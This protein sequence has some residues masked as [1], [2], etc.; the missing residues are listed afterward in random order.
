MRSLTGTPR[1][2][3]LAL[4][5]DR[6][7][8]PVWLLGI[9]GLLV[10]FLA[11]YQDT[12][13]TTD[14][15]RI[16]T[17]FFAENPIARMFGL[18]SGVNLG[19]YTLIEGYL[20]LVVLVG[21][22]SILAMVRHTRQSEETRQAEMLGATAVG[23]QALL[24]AALLVAFMANAAL[25]LLVTLV[26]VSFGLSLGS[27]LV[28]GVAFGGAGLAFASV[29]AVTVQI[30][31]SSRGASGMAAGVMGA[32][33]LLSAIGS[34]LGTV[35]ESGIVVD[36]AWPSWLSPIG[37]GQLMRPFAGDNWWLLL[38]LVGFFLVHCGIAFALL[39]R[40]DQGR[41]ILSEGRGP[42]NAARGLLS[43]IGLAWRLQRGVFF[44][45]AVGLAVSGLIVGAIA[46]DME[47]S[48]ADLDIADLLVSLGGTD[49][50][51]DAYF[52]AS[53]GFMGILVSAYAIQV[54]LRMRIEESD[55]PLESLLAM[56]LS[57]TRWMLS[58]T[59]NAIAGSLVLLALTGL[60]MG[61]TAGLTLG[62]MG[63]WL[64]D[65]TLAG[66]VLAPATFVIGA[67]S[68]LIFAVLPRRAAALSWAIFIIAMLTGPMFGE[69]LN[70]PDSVQNISPY[71]HTPGLPAADFT[72]TPLVIML[73]AA[74]ALALA[75]L[76]WFRRRDLAL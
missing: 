57:R 34:M 24:A 13:R 50:L 26:F 49:Q 73:A 43:P 60:S 1:L 63:A 41:G 56:H 75:G 67:A 42:A 40:R 8:L 74:V 32:A 54:L 69:M 64:L 3:R 37:W 11:I 58:Y 44:G 30:S 2:T 25:V 76:A 14:E 20:F 22:M 15:L 51:V 68:V 71:T 35:R 59:V 66:L 29:A 10:A 7:Q 52:V 6:I 23:R 46:S 47:A 62:D 72:A 18:P 17:E 39:E 45:W 9:A 16:A 21:L 31:S 4:R 33:V 5:R 19:A 12:Y 61:L 27:A 36:P 55:G 38:P 48:L 53:L 70:L 28:A 65:L